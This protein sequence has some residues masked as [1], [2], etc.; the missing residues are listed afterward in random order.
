[1]RR[2]SERMWLG[3]LAAAGVVLSHSLSFLFVAPDPHARQRLLDA[4]GH[5][6][7]TWVTAVAIGLLVAGVAGGTIKRLRGGFEDAAYGRTF[8]GSAAA[9]VLIQVVAFIALESVERLVVDGSP[10]GPLTD[11]VMAIGCVVQIVV[12]VVGALLLVALAH[13]VDHIAAR[14]LA[15]PPQPTGPAR[16]WWATS[17]M[18][19]TPAPATGGPTVRG[20]PADLG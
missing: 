3:G 13:G 14:F 18:P 9:L 5:R 4:T 1:M 19:P 7:F 15:S 8:V 12:A 10:L 2:V 17:V 16:A 20:P 6:Y 11:P